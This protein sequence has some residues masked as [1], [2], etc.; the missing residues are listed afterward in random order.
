MSTYV[1]RHPV[2]VQKWRIL[3]EQIYC[4]HAIVDRNYCIPVRDKTP[5]FSSVVYYHHLHTVIK[6]RQK[7]NNINN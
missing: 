5:G 3:L 1:S 2:L 7:L 6:L 4:L